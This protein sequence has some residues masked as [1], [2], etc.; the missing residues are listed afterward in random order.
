[1][2]ECFGLQARCIRQDCGGTRARLPFDH[3]LKKRVLK[4]IKSFRIDAAKTRE[5]EMY[6]QNPPLKKFRCRQINQQYHRDRFSD[7]PRSSRA[8]PGSSPI[9]LPRP[10]QGARNGRSSRFRPATRRQ[11]RPGGGGELRDSAAGGLRGVQT[12]ALGPGQRTQ[13][14]AAAA[15]AAADRW[16]LNRICEAGRPGRRDRAEA[17]GARGRRNAARVPHATTPGLCAASAA[18][19]GFRPGLVRACPSGSGC[20]AL[21]S[22]A[23]PIREPDQAPA[24]RERGN[25]TGAPWT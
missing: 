13:A 23:R 21:G 17:K 15:A 19:L 6:H 24:S 9:G 12:R 1:M 18:S 3:T 16:K 11:R 10:R 25:A 4:E 22:A 2:W 14:A 5:I 8:R 20:A 7:W